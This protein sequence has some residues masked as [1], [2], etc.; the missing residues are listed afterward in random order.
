M[1]VNGGGGRVNGWMGEMDGG[2]WAN[3]WAGWWMVNEWLGWVSG[4]IRVV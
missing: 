3:G 2:G 4:S 1:W